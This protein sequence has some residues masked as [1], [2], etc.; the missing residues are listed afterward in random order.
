MNHRQFVAI[1]A[2]LAATA[3]VGCGDGDTEVASGSDVPEELSAQIE[4]PG[5]VAP[6]I[7]VDTEEGEPPVVTYAGQVTTT[8]SSSTT[9]ST[10]TTSTSTAS[11]ITL[12]VDPCVSITLQTDTLFDTGLAVISP[13]ASAAL[14]DE[15]RPLVGCL[16]PSDRLEFVGWTDD[17]G[18]ESANLTL[19][20]D[21]ADAAEA[22]SLAEWPQLAGRT[23]AVG[24]GEIDPPS[25]C[26]GDCPANRIVVVSLVAGSP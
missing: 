21:R 16:S 1:G 5:A 12:L 20:Q 9:F 3:L 25:P 7:A 14:I 2:V 17:R 26:S 22:L 13:E 4:D 15:L 19:S 24:R 18:A 6:S 11:T 8:T 23:S 10:P